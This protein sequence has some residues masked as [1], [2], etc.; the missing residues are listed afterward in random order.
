MEKKHE[1]LKKRC[2]NCKFSEMG[3]EDRFRVRNTFG[4]TVCSK[5]RNNQSLIEKK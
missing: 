3:C 5:W 4:Y 2:F 1:K